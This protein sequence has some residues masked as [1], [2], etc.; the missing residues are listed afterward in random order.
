MPKATIVHAQQR[1]EYMTLTRRSDTYLTKDLNEVGQDG[2]E[3]VS[4][5][6]AKDLKGELSWTAFLKR[7]AAAQTQATS[8]REQAAEPSEQPSQKPEAVDASHPDRGFD[9][10]GD[11][12]E[13]K[14]EKS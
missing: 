10:S 14:E 12:F 13:I 3:L 9:L 1:W 11:E 6:Q 5:G 4:V 2:W 7:P 8:T